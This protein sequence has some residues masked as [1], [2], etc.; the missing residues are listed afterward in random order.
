MTNLNALAAELRAEAVCARKRATDTLRAKLGRQLVGKAEAHDDAADRLDALAR[1]GWRPIAEC[2]CDMSDVFMAHICGHGLSPDFGI[3]CRLE[4][5]LVVA[6]DSRGD[7]FD[8]THFLPPPPTR[9][10]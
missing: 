7:T 4:K 8:P 10:A 2:P 5:G 6:Y 3:G 1:E 9:D